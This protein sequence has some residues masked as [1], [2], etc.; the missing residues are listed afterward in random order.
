[1]EKFSTLAIVGAQWGDEGKGKVT[2]FA[3]QAAD[4]VVRYQ[5]G[6]NAGHTIVVNNVKYKLSLIPS[7][8]L[9]PNVKNVLANGMVINPKSF[10]KE[11]EILKMQG[12]VNNNLFVSNRAHIILDLHKSLDAARE[13]AKGKD[14]IGTTKKGIGPTYEDKYSRIGIRVAEFIQPQVFLIKLKALIKEKNILLAAYNLPT[15][16]AET[17]F[18]EYEPLIAQ[19]K[20]FVTD[21]SLLINQ[22]IE[23][24]ER[25]LF[26]GAQ[27]VLLCID[28]GTYPMV[29]SSSPTAA[30][31]PLYCGIK[32]AYVNKV[33]GIVKAYTTRVGGGPF[34]T[35][36]DGQLA[37]QIR[38][39]GNEYG[40]VTRRPRRIG[41]LDI[42]ALRYAKRVSGITDIALTLLDVLS[43]VAEIK[44]CVDYKI[45]NKIIKTMPADNKT[46]EQ[47]EPVYITMPGWNEDITNV[48]A[49]IDLP[50]NAQ[51]YLNKIKELT[52]LELSVFS[53]GPER[54]Q[55]I[56][57]KKL[58]S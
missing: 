25:V 9:T 16:N 39:R 2:D 24:N 28:H 15:L 58:F 29:T 32:P 55:T 31:I 50:K 38:E 17:I 48:S 12:I 23:N 47:V 3:C 6:N 36:I 53:V 56:I 13:I 42:V 41:W 33:L 19:I 57:L 7:G 51:N 4:M 18:N 20:P 5:G 46:L 37:H 30:S 26:E 11:L 54:K 10:L 14:S 49:F 21:T 22:A 44:I 52:N 45:N 27:G 43:G 40:T 1:M 34:V 8:V 35:E